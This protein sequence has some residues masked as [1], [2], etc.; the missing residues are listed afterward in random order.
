MCESEYLEFV[1]TKLENVFKYLSYEIVED[2]LNIFDKKY[3][4][5]KFVSNHYPVEYLESFKIP[6]LCVY[7]HIGSLIESYILD[8][9]DINGRP[10]VKTQ[11]GHY[12]G[13]CLCCNYEPLAK[14]VCKLGVSGI[15]KFEFLLECNEKNIDFVFDK[16]TVVEIE[17]G[18]QKEENLF[19]GSI[20]EKFKLGF[21]NFYN[22]ISHVN[23]DENKIVLSQLCKY[24][25]IFNLF[26]YYFRLKNDCF[27]YEK[28]IN[29]IDELRNTYYYIDDNS[30]CR[31]K[32]YLMG[33]VLPGV[34]YS[35]IRKSGIDFNYSVSE[36]IVERFSEIEDLIKNVIF[37]SIYK[38]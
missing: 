28:R 2:D 3:R 8:I 6:F 14:L 19:C 29:R 31:S 25:R 13:Y 1:K 5:L 21:N 4:F 10:V 9:E 26:I 34:L 32:E 7:K 24:I 37:E 22:Y 27:R 35:M 30:L 12:S 23:I 38:R 15:F 18:F 16:I 11:F 36:N 20:S 33:T 17:I